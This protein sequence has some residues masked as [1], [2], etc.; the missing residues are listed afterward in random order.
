MLMKR[1]ITIIFLGILIGFLGSKSV[2]AQCSASISLTDTIKCFG[3]YAT[4]EV[5]TVGGPGWY[6][7]QLE[8]EIFGNWY[9]LSTQTTYDTATFTTL[10]ANN[11]RVIINDTLGLCTTQAYINITQP[12]N[13][14]PTFTIANPSLCFGD[15]SAV[16]NLNVFGGISPYTAILNNGQSTPI[17]ANTINYFNLLSGTY[18]VVVTDANGCVKTRNKTIISPAAIV[19]NSVIS[20]NYN[21][22]DISCYGGSDGAILA[23]V[24]SGG[25]APFQFSVNGGAFS[26]NPY[27][28][29][30]SSGQH[31]ITYRDTN[32]CENA[33]TL[34]LLDP[35]DLRGSISVTSAISCN[36]ICDGQIAFTVDPNFPGTQN[37][38]YSLGSGFYQTSPIFGGLC[39]DLDYYITVK[40][41]NGC[42]FTDSLFLN[43]PDSLNIFVS[44]LSNYNN[45]GV[46]CFGENDGIISVDSV[47]GGTPTYY[48]AID[49]G[50]YGTSSFFT[51]LTGGAHSITV[52]DASGCTQSVNITITEPNPYGISLT[53]NISYNGYDVACNGDCNG[54]INVTSNGGVPSY[55][56][57]LNGGASQASSNFNGQ[58]ANNMLVVSAIDAN[59][60]EAVDSIMLIE[61]PILTI[62]MDSVMENCGAGDGQAIASA[63]GGVSPYFY[64]WNDGQTT[65]TAVN[66]VSGSYTVIVTDTNGCSATK[67]V[68]VMGTDM[69]LLS[70]TTPV[71]CNGGSD[72]TGSVTVTGSYA[73]PLTYQWNDP[74]FQSSATATGL[75]SGNYIVTVTDGNGCSIND[76][77]N[78]S[79][80][81]V[82][83]IELDS[84]NSL[85]SVPCFGDSLG[86]ASVSAT[87]GSGP[88]TFWFYI[89][90][91]N[92]QNDSSFYGLPSGN[93]II[94]VNDVNGCKDSIPV[95]ISEP[96]EIVFSLSSNDVLCNGGSSGNAEVASISGGTPNYSYLWNTG[97]TT[98]S[99]GGLTIGTYWL[100]VTDTNGCT[101]YPP[102]TVIINEPSQLITS[103]SSTPA[104]CG[105]TLANGTAAVNV[106][107]G[108]TSY[109][110]LWNTGA[111]TSNIGLLVS[112]SYTVIVTDSNGC[113]ANDTVFVQQDP[114]PSLNVSVQNVSCFGA[115]DGIITPTAT[116]GTNPYQFS[117]NGGN[118]WQ[119]PGIQYGPSGQAAYF[120]TVRDSNGCVVSDSVFVLEPS[121]LSI[122]SFTINEVSCYGGSDGEITVNHSGGTQGGFSYS[123]SN[124]QTSQTATGLSIGN[125][126]VIVTDLNG[127]TDTSSIISMTQPDSLYIQSIT[128]TDVLCNGGNDGAA[129]VNAQGGVLPYSY[130][131][132]NGSINQNISVSAGNY[133]VD[134]TDFNGCIVIDSITVNEPAL[135]VTDSFVMDSVLCYGFSDG[136]ATVYISG[137]ITPYN[138]QWDNG[139]NTIFADSLN[140]GYHTVSITDFNNCLH[141]DSVLILQPATYVSIDSLIVAQNTCKDA[142]NG[143]IVV[144][145]TG[146][147]PPY[148]Y[149]KDGGNNYQSAIGFIGLAENNYNIVVKDDKGCTASIIQTIT[150]PDSLLIDSIDFN[151][152]SCNGYSNGYIQSISVSGGTQPYMYSVNGYGP[153]PS[154]AYFNGYGPGNYTVEVFDNN[155]CV[156]ADLI[157][158]E[159][160]PVLNSSII[161]S[162]Y[163]GYE[164]RCNGDSSGWISVNVNGGVSPYMKTWIDTQGDSIQSGFNILLDSLNAGLYTLI[165]ADANGCVNSQFITLNE[166]SQLMHNTVITHVSCDGWSNG[167]ITDSIYGGVPGYTYLWNTG[168]TTYAITDLPIG[169]YSI[170]V[171]DANNCKS[172]T[173]A[174]VND[175][176]KLSASIA[177]IQ[178]VI[179][180]GYCD[181]IIEVNI[182]GG[183]P[184]FD[185]NGNPTYQNIWNDPLSQITSTA[186]GL[187]SDDNTL[188]RNYIDSITDAIGCQ[189][190][191]NGNVSQPL[192]VEVTATIS[193]EISCYAGNDG[194]IQAN[195]VGGSPAY[196]YLWNNQQTGNT[197]NN[198]VTGSYIV[199]STDDNGCMD[200]T[201]IY[202]DEPSDL[203]L[204]VSSFNINC[205]GDNDGSI[206]ASPSGGTPISP[207]GTY[208]YLW[209]DGQ[210][211]QT[212][213]SLSPGIY[214]VTVTDGNGC[215]IS[216]SNILVSQ[217]L[218]ELI[219][220]VDSTDETCVMDDGTA[221]ANV[222]GGTLP[223][224]SYNWSPG[225]QSTQIATGLSPG[226]YSV[227]VIDANG[228]VSNANTHI[229]A[230]DAIFMP[231]FSDYFADTICLGDNITI[232]TLNNPNFTYTWNTG[233]LTSTITVKPTSPR[234]DYVLTVVDVVNCPNSSFDVTASIWTNQLPIIPIATPNP[235]KVGDEVEIRAA[236]SN[237]YPTYLWVDEKGE[238]VA[239]SKVTYVYPDVSTTYYIMVEDAQGCQ[240]YDSVRV[241]VGVIVYDG[242][243]PNG[244]GYNDF[245]EIEDIDRYPDAEI[246]VY[247]RWG[248][249]LFSAKGNTYNNNKWDGTQNG[250]LLPVGTY[251]YIINLNNDSELQSG[252]ITIIR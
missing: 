181:G 246:E 250:E 93:Y 27:F 198:L 106:S 124:F 183:M 9:Q 28:Q 169:T 34:Y 95:Q 200:T 29:G 108:V 231:D 176:D 180:F 131:W 143:S 139:D 47:I 148:T 26:S 81:N 163:N 212:A 195:T 115:N 210:I 167:N 213:N 52:A 247:N 160:P 51:G 64:L 178:D 166:P 240:G 109:S 11:Y 238:Y 165:V 146:G 97:A 132:S 153:H 233:D 189:V 103:T 17:I 96:D 136:G 171:T 63:S 4:I 116:G 234:T 126:S 235:I 122:D 78:I 140:A 214:D 7:Y 84:I 157:I 245:W 37:Y 149:S 164:I 94:F 142:S 188:Q 187:C 45:W 6:G 113:I 211:T 14:V 15:S 216:S 190:V 134:V 223:Y 201:E 226:N 44:V 252:A 40:D 48:Y 206:T 50:N 101:I 119:N 58:C 241:V 168:D 13:I 110:Y 159:Q 185:S 251:Y 73:M 65:P 129:V 144:L 10:P 184:F 111:I 35:Q 208:T 77:L 237:N 71:S 194:S 75:S 196:T 162:N 66:L 228:C 152:V 85:Y 25:T 147:M 3:D 222:F 161:T 55:L 249:I 239:N 82:V 21:G 88:G 33:D 56:Y 117:I 70:S 155:N 217:P 24:S 224:S 220:T 141:V 112:G 22:Q 31:I 229:N 151:H 91:A 225:S 133:L 175:N 156:V 32:G 53:K 67:N 207:S 57:S 138:Y 72:G 193:N 197:I 87:G 30:L 242:I 42:T 243:S 43:Q 244:D 121:I 62:Q 5:I 128:S 74:N 203:E 221:I 118:T 49:G 154:L 2:N 8:Y 248:V 79:E 54:S 158:I 39:G 219:V 186:I 170:N 174:I 1:N 86:V 215:V 179:C 18:Q 137:G 36:S 102:D 59:G 107:G 105:G 41:I 90:A 127:C 218:S 61:P 230:F 192:E 99:I 92:P 12:P 125:F 98:D 83:N 177:N 38:Q 89:D 19:P 150:E 123:W 114:E 227:T 100:T 172:L 145:A 104:I 120:V 204:S 236:S 80:P 191:V 76:T 130:M 69:I 202:L 205:Y 60:C 23:Q 16:L 46:S 209:S 199:V 232:S 20:S 182:S 135:I 68:F 173:S